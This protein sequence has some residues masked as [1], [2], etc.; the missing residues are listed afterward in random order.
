MDSDD[1]EPEEEEKEE[2]EEVM[3]EGGLG[4]TAERAHL[5]YEF[6]GTRMDQIPER[7]NLKDHHHHI[8]PRVDKALDEVDAELNMPYATADFQRIAINLL[9]AGTNVVLVSE[10][11][12]AQ[13]FHSNVSKFGQK[14]TKIY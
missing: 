4:I 7:I 10:C 1:E 13:L 14:I 5:N 3:T 2:E 12:S 9:G 11:G 8:D 6:A